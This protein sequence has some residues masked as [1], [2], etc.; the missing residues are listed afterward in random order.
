MKAVFNVHLYVM[1]LNNSE[2]KLFHSEPEDYNN[3]LAEISS[4]M[5]TF[6]RR[7]SCDVDLC[8]LDILEA[9]DSLVEK[10]AVELEAGTL[11]SGDVMREWVGLELFAV[12]T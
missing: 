1:K 4:M 10:M 2:F 11:C 7:V 12:D 6:S 3:Q 8:Q 9:I 5:T